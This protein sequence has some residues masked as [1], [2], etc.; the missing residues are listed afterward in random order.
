[1]ADNPLD[2][3][4]LAVGSAGDEHA[5]VTAAQQA[6]GAVDQLVAARA[7]AAGVATAWSALGRA[8]LA[9]AVRLVGPGAGTWFASGS[10]G[11]GEALPGADVETL[12]IRAGGVDFDR[13]SAHAVQVHDV[14]A[15]CGFRGDD[16]GVTAA[17]ARFNRTAREWGG[18]I[19][20]WAGA[21]E[22]DRGV[23]MVGLLADAVAVSTA[24]REVDL[25]DE[26][27]VAARAHP[28]VLAAMLQDATYVRAQVPSRLRVFAARDDGVDVKFAIV[29]PVVRIARWAALC[30][31]SA[32]MT[33]P[34]RLA[35]AAGSR[36]L[37][38]DDAAVLARCYEIGSSIRW[39]VRAY[40]WRTCDDRVELAALAP[41]DRTALRSIAAEVSRVR[42]KLDYLAS[43][44]EFSRW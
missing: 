29:D 25:R 31:G 7:R 37:D 16:N 10:V 22:A 41:Q 9:A 40:T 1:M 26:A 38:A 12:L 17:R 14:L 44:S 33:T 5:L 32:A 30:C 20:G 27:G 21:P 39:R 28:Q 11:R 19:A 8:V 23:V 34:Q 15:A 6:P 4:C 13:A 43:T 36:Y 2:T 18:S 35:D 24:L 42:R 3:V